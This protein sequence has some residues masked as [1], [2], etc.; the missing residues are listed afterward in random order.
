MSH[1]QEV[2]ERAHAVVA[3]LRMKRE[4]EAERRRQVYGRIQISRPLPV[5]RRGVQLS[6]KLQ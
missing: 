4:Q 6:L 5:P 1:S 3:T 2:I